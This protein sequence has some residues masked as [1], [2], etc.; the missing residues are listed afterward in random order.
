MPSFSMG[1]LGFARHFGTHNSANF[2]GAVP[3]L[4]AQ[5]EQ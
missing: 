4:C 5:A 3:D 2:P 1:I